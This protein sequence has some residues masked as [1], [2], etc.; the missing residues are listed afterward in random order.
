MHEHEDWLDRA[1]RTAEPALADDGF[2]LR[3][4]RALPA[5]RRS[6]LGERADWI[7]IGGTALGSAVVA[8]QFPLGPVLKL[9]VQSAQITWLGGA[10]MLACMASAL[11]AEQL[12]RI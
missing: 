5:P 4:M 9:F 11:L 10:L 8:A 3:V 2:T 6:R 7:V 1:L 12:R